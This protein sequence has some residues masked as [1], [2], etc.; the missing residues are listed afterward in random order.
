[1]DFTNK[2]VIITGASSGIGAGAAKHL[3]NL[4]AKLV[5]TGRNKDNLKE[6]AKSCRGEV[7]PL[8]SDVT[9]EADRKSV[10]EE[11]I[12]R[13]GKI[14]VLVNNAGI[15]AFGDVATT[16][17]D[18]FDSLM[19][20]N[21]RSVFHLTQLAV[22]HLIKTK[23]NIVNTSSAAGLRAFPGVS[24]Y[25]MTKAALDQFTRCLALELAPQGVRVNSINPAVI[26]TNFLKRLG[27]DEATYQQYLVKAKDAH[28]LGRVGTVDETAHAIAFLACNDTASFI[29]GTNLAVDG[30]RVV[31]C[32]R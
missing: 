15:G 20:T 19:N 6:V 25:C 7:L 3:S 28:P 8:V 22:P 2:V 21:L 10:I 11:T 32:P 9:S 4:G 13:F 23:G 5:I 31:S 14:D 12:R 16:T 18:S 24:V 1:M 27:M 26:K 30:G 29:T 17:M